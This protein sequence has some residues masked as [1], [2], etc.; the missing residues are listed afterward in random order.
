MLREPDQSH[1]PSPG[2]TCPHAPSCGLF[3]GIPRT[4]GAHF[5]LNSGKKAQLSSLP[6]P[7]QALGV[8]GQVEGLGYTV[9]DSVAVDA[10]VLVTVDSG[11]LQG[12]LILKAC[13]RGPGPHTGSGEACRHALS[14]EEDPGRRGCLVHKQRKKAF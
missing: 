14:S 12:L 9:V 7:L 11:T 4:P 10:Q 5:E 8:P 2:K 1:K 13:E 3:Q 6:Q